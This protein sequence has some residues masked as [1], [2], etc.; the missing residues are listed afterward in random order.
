MEKKAERIKI[1]A[2]AGPTASGKTAVGVRLAELLGGEVVSC[3][4]MQIYR[5]MKIGTAAPTREEM[6]GIPHH[7]IGFCDPKRNYSVADY[8]EDAKRAVTDISGRGKIP[9]IVGGTG[10]YLDSLLFIG[11]FSEAGEDTKIREELFRIARED[12]PAALHSILR[13]IDAEAAEKI[14]EN[15]TKRVVR[16]I[17]VYKLTGKTKTETDREALA[18]SPRYDADVVTLIF[19]NRQVLYERIDKRVDEMF[20]KGL[21]D[22]VRGLLERGELSDG[23][24]AA[25]A[26]GYRETVSMIKGET[27]RDDAI[28]LIKKN[29]RNYAKRQLTWFRRYDGIKVTVDES[30]TVKTAD[31][32]VREIMRRI[33]EQ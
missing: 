3:D 22:E 1:L 19:E 28:E 14:H 15:N 4:S 32:T 25:Q 11:S 33:K 9:I 31:E 23:S 30:G 16:A 5:G 13:D 26:I 20:E 18:P 8:V 6:H 7:L 10:L 27:G 2:V 29:T 12:G 17:E 21:E 24:T